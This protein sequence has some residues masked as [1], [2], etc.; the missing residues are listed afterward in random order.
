MATWDYTASDRQQQGRI[1]SVPGNN[2]L[3]RIISATMQPTDHTS[4]G[5]GRGDDGEVSMQTQNGEKENTKW[6]KWKENDGVVCMK[7]KHEWEYSSVLRNWGGEWLWLHPHK[8]PV[9]IPDGSCNHT[10]FT[11][12]YISSHPN[13]GKP[14]YD[15]W[16]T[17]FSYSR[18]LRLLCNLSHFALVFVVDIS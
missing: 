12:T 18:I 1:R 9:N 4:T 17:D 13:Y 3:P 7:L 6:E 2:T 15:R 8:H 5:G 14:E 11:V 10:P 16:D